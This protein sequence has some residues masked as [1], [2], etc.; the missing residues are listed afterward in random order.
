MS[1]FLMYDAMF[2]TGKCTNHLYQHAFY[3]RM[4]FCGLS[5]NLFAIKVTKQLSISTSTCSIMPSTLLSHSLQ[6]LLTGTGGQ[7]V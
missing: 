4:E 1:D 5:K 3:L 2:Y 7:G 6:H